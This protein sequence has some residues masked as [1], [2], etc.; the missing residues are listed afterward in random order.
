[1]WPLDVR[2][3]TERVVAGVGEQVVLLKNTEGCAQETQIHGYVAVAVVC[4]MEAEGG[5]EE[6]THKP[7]A[8]AAEGLE[9]VHIVAAVDLVVIGK[10][11]AW[12]V[13][14]AE[15]TVAAAIEVS[16]VQDAVAAH[17]DTNNSADEA[18]CLVQGLV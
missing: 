11:A 13:D 12:V 17:T 16:A 1:M 10:R 7:S 8:G 2:A 3:A 5:V 15:K 14:A 9:E 4:H 6:H 18:D